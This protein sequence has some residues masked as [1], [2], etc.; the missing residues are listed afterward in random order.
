MAVKAEFQKVREDKVRKDAAVA[1]K[2]LGILGRVQGLAR[3]LG[4]HV[5]DDAAAGP[6]PGPDPEVGVRALGSAGLHGDLDVSGQPLQEELQGRVK[7]GFP[8]VSP[9][10]NPGQGLQIVVKNRIHVAIVRIIPSGSPAFDTV[11]E[12]AGISK[13]LPYSRS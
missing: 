9:A 1:A 5:A 7:A 10:D 8:E 12:P 6:I 3:G 13:A 2:L 11:R 4:L